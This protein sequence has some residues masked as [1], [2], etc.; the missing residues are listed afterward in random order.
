M[1]VVFLEHLGGVCS[2]LCKKC[3]TFLSNCGNCYD[4][5]FVGVSGTAFLFYKVVNVTH[6][7]VRDKYTPTGK[8]K[9][10]RENV[11]YF[12]NSYL[13][14]LDIYHF[15]HYLVY[16]LI[17]IMYVLMVNKYLLF[18]DSWRVLQEV[19]PKSRLVLWVRLRGKRKM[20]AGQDHAGEE[21]DVEEERDT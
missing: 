6:G 7:E 12:S 14:F 21:Q 18:T 8:Y 3:G 4:R 13:F 2:F 19:H 10:R 20:E 1:G 11:S 9:V 15:K 17:C 5:R 16:L